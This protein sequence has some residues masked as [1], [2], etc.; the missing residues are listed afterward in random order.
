M[1][2]PQKIYDLLLEYANTNT[3]IQE[4]IIG[5]T[6]TFCKS[7]GVGLCMSPGTATRTLPWSGTLVNKPISEIASWLLSWDAYQATVGMAA[8]NSVINSNS[9]LP[10]TGVP[11]SPESSANLAVFEHFLPQIRNQKVCIIGRY[12]G[13]DK[14][15]DEMQMNVLE[16]QPKKGDFPAPASEYLLPKADWVF[17]TATSIVNKTFP[18][19]VE[20]SQNAQLVLM[21]P[22]L[23]WLTELAEMGINYLAGVQVSNLSALRQTVAE[24]GGVRIFETGIEYRVVKVAD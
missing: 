2:H 21:G 4:I 18:R 7:E 14:Y 23:P 13:L 12:P 3:Q 1:I 6:W 11:L 15:K 8:I 17:L 5:L 10:N 22:T 20:L 16:L 9:S 19:L 24:G